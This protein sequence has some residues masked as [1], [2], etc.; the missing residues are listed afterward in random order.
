MEIIS[1]SVDDKTLEDLNKMQ[2]LLGFK[3]RSKLLRSTLNSLVSEYKMVEGLKGHIDAVYLLTYTETEKHRISDMLH[4]FDDSI[5][6]LIHQHHLGVCLEILIVC[7]EAEKI[8]NLF[9]IL[10]RDKGVKS[11]SCSVL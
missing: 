2:K 4:K 7:A 1:I 6:T 3:S 10:K 8:R 11:V 9:S 5:K